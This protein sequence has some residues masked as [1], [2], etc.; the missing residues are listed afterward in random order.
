MESQ[1]RVA[2]HN[3]TRR[4][5]PLLGEDPLTELGQRQIEAALGQA[6][7][8]RKVAYLPTTGSTNDVAKDLAAR[9]AAEG[10]VVVA[11]QQTAGRGRLGRRWLAPPAT[12]LLCSLLFR[13]VLSLAQ[14]NRLT[15]LSSLAAADAVREVAGL[16]VSLKW[17]ND[18]IVPPTWKKLSGV[19]TETGMVGA[20]LDFVVVGIGVNVNVPPEA[21][22]DLDPNATSILAETGRV[23]DRL[24]L[25]TAFLAEVERR[26]EALRAGANPRQEWAGRLA[27][28]GRSVKATTSDG[29]FTGVAESVDEDGALLLRAPGGALRRLVAGDVTL[30]H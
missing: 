7:F 11:D 25:L 4:N 19:L 30:A 28:L 1:R 2:A 15:M 3:A 17:P 14:A 16:R 21:L 26:Y 24:T 13:P 20:Q 8:W 6:T 29:V 9:G 12:C 10:T 23:V 27:T 18:L 5:L 22:P